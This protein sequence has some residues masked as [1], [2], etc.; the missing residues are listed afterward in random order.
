MAQ[1]DNIYWERWE[2]LLD[3]AANFQGLFPGSV[4]IGGSAAAIHLGHRYSFN[5]E[6]K[7]QK[8]HGFRITGVCT[9]GQA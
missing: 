1:T 4:M 5:E 3:A 6:F 7:W 8:I 2:R 9:G